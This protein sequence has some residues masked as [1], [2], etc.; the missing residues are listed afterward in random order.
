M[1]FS[2]HNQHYNQLSFIQMLSQSSKSISLKEFWEELGYSKSTF[3]RRLSK[4]GI[5]PKHRLLSPEE[6]DEYRKLLG[7]PPKFPPHSV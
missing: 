4:I 7:F 3:Y 6:Q 2:G 1:F 5:K